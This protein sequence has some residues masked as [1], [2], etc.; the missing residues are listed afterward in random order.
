[1]IVTRSK[2][3]RIIYMEDLGA[4]SLM[5]PILCQESHS[6]NSKFRKKEENS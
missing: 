6:G 1:M 2:Q 3:N 5:N 4:E